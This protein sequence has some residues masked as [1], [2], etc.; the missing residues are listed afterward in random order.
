MHCLVEYGDHHDDGRLAPRVPIATAIGVISALGGVTSIIFN[1]F[2]GSII[3]NFCY[4]IQIYVGA[5]LHP[6][7]ALVLAV[8]FL[9]RKSLIA[10]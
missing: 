1:G 8:F 2:V 5:T 3:D 9:R 10:R 4:S 6:L 7:G